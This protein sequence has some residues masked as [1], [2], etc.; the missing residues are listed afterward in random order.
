MNPM[1]LDLAMDSVR[2]LTVTHP[3][4]AKPLSSTANDLK[5]TSSRTG[6]VPCFLRWRHSRMR[7]ALGVMVTLSRVA[8][9]M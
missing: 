8:L 3:F 1:Q 6:I 4:S 9:Q 5:L 2:G 7:S